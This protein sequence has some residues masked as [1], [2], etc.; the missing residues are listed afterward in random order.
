MLR[1]F[2]VCAGNHVGEFTKFYKLFGFTIT[3]PAGDFLMVY[4]PT[5]HPKGDTQSSL[6]F[7]HR[8]WLCGVEMGLHE[9]FSRRRANVKR[10][11]V[12]EVSCYALGTDG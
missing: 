7:L 8:V 11:T 2:G 4:L 5:S 6:H 12:V 9:W 3:Q 10:H 1:I